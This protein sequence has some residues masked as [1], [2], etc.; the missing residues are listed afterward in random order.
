MAIFAQPVGTW[1]GSTL[2]GRVL[3]GLIRNRVGFGFYKKKLKPDPY[4]NP[5]PK[6]TKI[7]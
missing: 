5:V 2:M 3:P 6:I 7:P 4:K 1:P